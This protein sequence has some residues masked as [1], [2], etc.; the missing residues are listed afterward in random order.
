MVYKSQ[1]IKTLTFEEVPK[2]FQLCQ[3]SQPFIG[4]LNGDQIDDFIFN[5]CDENTANYQ[6]G[7]MQV[8]IYNKELHS[9]DVGAFRDKM[10]D[11]DCGGLESL[12]KKPELTT[13]HSV[14]MI[15]FDGDCLSDLFVTV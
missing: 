8:A 15:D 1:P 11:P 4:D 10:V 9:Y 13:P 2:V 5:N 14:S 6:Y 12:I 3:G 7:K